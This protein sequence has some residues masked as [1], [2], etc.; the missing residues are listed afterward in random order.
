MRLPN[1][2]GT[3]CKM[4]GKRRRPWMARLKSEYSSDGMKLTQTRQIVGYYRTKQEALEALQAYHLDPV[5][6][7]DRSTFADLFALWIAEKALSVGTRTVTSYKAAFN[8]CLAI[9]NIPIRDIKLQQLQ[10]VLDTYPNASKSTLD[11]ITIVISNVYSYAMRTDLIRKDLSKYI[12]I[13]AY[14]DPTGKH[15]PFT[16]KEIAALWTMP[17]SIER[18]VV[19]ILLYTGWRVTE[20]LDMPRENIDLTANTMTGGKKTKAGRGRVVPI[21]STILPMVKQ[22]ASAPVPFDVPYQDVYDWMKEHTGHMPHDTRHTFISELK[23]RGA[24]SVC[25]ER[26]VGHESKSITEKVYTHKDLAELRRTVELVQYKDIAMSAA[27]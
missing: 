14:A 26:I 15:K 5:D 11:N 19:L 13:H 20:L 7:A 2:Y 10:A 21:H 4:S 17:Q 16:V 18:D 8:K 24:D 23:S 6:L 1:G 9:H 3:V 12:S 22:Y 25:I 27:M